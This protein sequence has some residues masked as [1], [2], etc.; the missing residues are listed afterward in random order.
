MQSF[1]KKPPEMDWFSGDSSAVFL[2]KAKEIPD[3]T[4]VTQEMLALT[5][6]K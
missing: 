5:A 6:K 2:P 3:F 1:C 4:D